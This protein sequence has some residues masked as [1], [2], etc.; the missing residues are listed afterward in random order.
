MSH[1]SFLNNRGVQAT[2]TPEGRLN[3][4]GLSGLSDETRQEVVT[5][6]RENKAAILSGLQ[7]PPPDL[8]Q[9]QPGHAQE[10]IT[11]WYSAWTLADYV[12]GGDATAPY[13][14]RVAR[15]PELNQII[16]RMRDIEDSSTPGTPSQAKK[17]PNIPADYTDQDPDTCPACGQ[18]Q[19]W[20][21]NKP[22]STWIC[23]RCHPPATGLD[24][25]SERIIS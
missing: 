7:P 16:K 21:K 19:W 25:I 22:N 10:Y 12:D 15:L 13:P 5:F 14:D 9:I 6:A 17:I 1:L 3:L 2:V 11:L 8:S 20:R 23:G 4:K 24:V 18:N